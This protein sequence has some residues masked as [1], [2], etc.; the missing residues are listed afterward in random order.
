MQMLSGQNFCF[1]IEQSN[2]PAT[3]FFFLDA[4]QNDLFS[5]SLSDR[6]NAEGRSI[7]SLFLLTFSECFTGCFL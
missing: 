7:A 5:L 4:S 1:V 6:S 2:L 3:D